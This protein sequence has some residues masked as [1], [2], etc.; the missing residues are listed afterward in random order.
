MGPLLDPT[1]YTDAM[2]KSSGWE[3]ANLTHEK[4]AQLLDPSF[5]R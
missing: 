4:Q 2:V 3:N 1:F 5:L